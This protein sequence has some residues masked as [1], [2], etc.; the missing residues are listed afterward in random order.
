[1]REP[2]I[3]SDNEIVKKMQIIWS[4]ILLN[5]STEFKKT[6]EGYLA[7]YKELCKDTTNTRVTKSDDHGNCKVRKG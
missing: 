4:S 2:E 6:M 1:M 5:L 7:I 3:C